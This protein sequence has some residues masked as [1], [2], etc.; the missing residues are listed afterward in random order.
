VR[1]Y[2]ESRPE[3][4][5]RWAPGGG[6]VVGPHGGGRGVCMSDGLIMNEI[7][8]QHKRYILVGTLRG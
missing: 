8:A 7:W 5:K 3:V 4:P 1:V 2:P 6:G